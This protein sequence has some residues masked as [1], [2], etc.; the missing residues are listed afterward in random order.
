MPDVRLASPRTTRVMPGSGM[1]KS[2]K[3]ASNCGTTAMPTNAKTSS[4][5]SRLR[6]G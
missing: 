4:V 5:T 6:V 1:P 3:I 2:W